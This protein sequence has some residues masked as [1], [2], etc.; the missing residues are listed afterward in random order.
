MSKYRNQVKRLED[1]AT[2]DVCVVFVEL[3]WC[4]LLLLEASAGEAELLTVVLAATE[5]G[6]KIL[7]VAAIEGEALRLRIDRLLGRARTSSTTWPEE[8]L[9]REVLFEAAITSLANLALKLLVMASLRVL[10]VVLL[11][12]LVVLLLLSTIM[13]CCIMLV[14]ETDDDCTFVELVVAEVL[15]FVACIE[16]D[17]CELTLFV[18]FSSSLNNFELL[19]VV[20]VTPSL[21]LGDVFFLTCDAFNSSIQGAFFFSH[22]LGFGL[23]NCSSPVELSSDF[24]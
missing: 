7:R 18:V 19:S 22:S 5:F 10:A 4:V 13:D 21:T 12:L 17:T 3:E 6:F 16:L 2:V 23:A 20:A 11:L 14:E 8:L 9:L 24:N 15:E 1:L